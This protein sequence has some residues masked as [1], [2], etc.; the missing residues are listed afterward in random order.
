M[1]GGRAAGRYLWL[2]GVTGGPG[3]EGA[4]SLRGVSIP[5]WP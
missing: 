3:A 4:P 2:E 1:A 5:S